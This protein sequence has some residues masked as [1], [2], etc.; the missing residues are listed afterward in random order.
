M[1]P[2]Q[3]FQPARQRRVPVPVSRRRGDSEINS[4]IL[5]KID[6]DAHADHPTLSNAPAL[7]ASIVV[8]NPTASRLGAGIEIISP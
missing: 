6:N 5:I 3:P 2:F 1:G 4:G 8:G 7:T